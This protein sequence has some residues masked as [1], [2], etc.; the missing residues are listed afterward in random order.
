[1]AARWT[2]SETAAAEEARDLPVEALTNFR[3]ESDTL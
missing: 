3:V 2:L 1:M